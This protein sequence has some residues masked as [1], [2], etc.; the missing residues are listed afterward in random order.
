MDVCGFGLDWLTLT[1]VVKD[2]Q[3]SLP[4]MAHFARLS[5]VTTKWR[6]NGYKG[7][8]DTYN[9][10][11]YGSR[12]RKDGMADEI[13]MLSGPL[14]DSLLAKIGST[15]TYRAT[16]VDIEITV[17][18]DKCDEKLASKWYDQIALQKRVGTSVAGRRKISNIRSDSGQTLYVGTRKTGRK[19][20]RF[21]DKSLDLDAPL[22]LVWRQEVQYGRDLADEALKM[23]VNIR[24]NKQ[25]VID[26]VCAEFTDCVGFT[27]P[28]P[29]K[30]KNGAQMSPEP[31]ITTVQ[32]KLEWLERCVKP[33]IALL[34]EEGLESEAR[35]ALGLRDR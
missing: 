30:I 14:T 23:Y 2:N 16:R 27:L 4:L 1:N 21:Y 32:A 13:L 17:V 12:L 15:E 6:G 24:G 25:A 3:E 10:L 7:S 31:K 5:G 29:T 8:Q 9:G 26:L 20:F 22:G 19:F 35:S 18:L 11:R 34:M 33:T 28:I